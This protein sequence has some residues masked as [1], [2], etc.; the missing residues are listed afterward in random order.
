MSLATRL[1]KLERRAGGGPLRLLVVCK[2]IGGRA[3]EDGKEPKVERVRPCFIG[4]WP[5]TERAAK[6][7][8]LRA[9]Y[10]GVPI[11]EARA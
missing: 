7:D 3:S 1:D 11:D 8:R 2:V 10:P 6:I 9:E 4:E 5:E